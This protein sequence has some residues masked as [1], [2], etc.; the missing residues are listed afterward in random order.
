MANDGQCLATYG[1]TYSVYAA[2]S[3]WN[4]LPKEHREAKSVD[5]FQHK[6]MSKKA[7]NV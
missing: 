6:L 3:I 1:N 5:C 4:K 7:F 2:P